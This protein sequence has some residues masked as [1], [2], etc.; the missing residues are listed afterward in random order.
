M[1]GLILGFAL[2]KRR[3][4][5]L[6]L[7]G[8]FPYGS[9]NGNFTKPPTILGSSQVGKTL[10]F[11][12]SIPQVRVLPAQPT[13]LIYKGEDTMLTKGV[14]IKALKEAGIRRGNK[15]GAEVKLEH[16]KTYQVIDLYYTY[17]K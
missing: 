14:M 11:G 3:S 6:V 15:D 16:L 8:E 1:N 2:C 13:I 17:C 12:S 7:F 9:E 5:W 10:D 4:R